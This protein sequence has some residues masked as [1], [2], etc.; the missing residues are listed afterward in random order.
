MIVFNETVNVDT[1]NASAITLQSLYEAS[2]RESYTLTNS[3][4]VS[5]SSTRLVVM[6][7][8]QDQIE[9][10][11]RT[12]LCEGQG[13]CYLTFTSA[14]VEDMSGNAVVAQEPGSY[15]GLIAVEFVRDQ[16]PPQLREFVFD[17]QNGTFLLTF[18]EPVDVSAVDPTGIHLQGDMN[19][20][21]SYTLTGGTASSDGS[22]VV[23]FTVASTDLYE[24]QSRLLYKSVNNSY[25]S[26]D[27]S[28]FRDVAYQPNQVAAI[29]QDSALQATDYI[30]DVTGPAIVSYILDLDSDSLVLSFSEVVDIT[31]LDATALYFSTLNSTSRVTLTGGI[32][33]NIPLER[34]LGSERVSIRLTNP[35]TVSLKTADEIAQIPELTCLESS[36][37]VARDTAGNL[38]TSQDPL[39]GDI[40]VSD[41]TPL[42]LVAFDLDID[43]GQ[44][45]LTFNDVALGSTFNPEAITIQDNT[46][47]MYQFSL[48]AS[49]YTN[50]NASHVI[51]VTLGAEDLF[52]LKSTFGIVGDRNTTYLTLRADAIDDIQMVDVIAITDTNA[53]QVTNFTEDTTPPTLSNFDLNMNLSTLILTFSEGVDIS[54]LQVGNIT[55]YSSANISAADAS[56]TLTG[57]SISQSADG[58]VVTIELTAADMNTIK[59]NVMLGTSQSDTFLS[60]TDAL[61]QDLGGNFINADGAD[62]TATPVTTFVADVTAPVLYLFTLDMDSGTLVL[63][64]SETMMAVSV[65]ANEF[66]IQNRPSLSAISMDVQLTDSAVSTDNS[67][68]ITIT[69]SP[70]DLNSIKLARQLAIDGHTTFLFSNATVSAIDMASNALQPFPQ[71]SAV[72]VY[73]Y[74]RDQTHP[75]LVNFT[76]DRNTGLFQL[77]FSEVIE[78]QPVFQFTEITI[79]SGPNITSALNHTLELEGLLRPAYEGE[80]YIPVYNMTPHLSDYHNIKRPIGLAFNTSSTF[81]SLTSSTTADYVGHPVVPISNEMAMQALEVFPDIDPPPYVG[82]VLNVNRQYLLIMWDDVIDASTVMVEQVQLVGGDGITSENTFNFTSRSNVTQIN[83]LTVEITIHDDD[84]N[85]IKENTLVAADNLTTFLFLAGDTVRDTSGNPN[86][87]FTAP[88]NVTRYFYDTTRPSLVEFNVSIDGGYMLMLFS[89]TV[90]YSSLVTSHLAFQN[91]EVLDSSGILTLTTASMT[92]GPHSTVLNVT[93]GLEDLNALKDRVDLATTVNDT[94]LSF[95]P[96][97]LADMAGNLINGR[98]TSNALQATSVIPDITEPTL[99]QFTLNLEDA[100]ITLYFSETVDV[101]SFNVTEISL[102]NAVGSNAISITITNTS[103]FERVDYS[104]VLVNL[105]LSDINRIKA[106]ITLGTTVNDTFLTA[107]SSAAKDRNDN[108][109]VAIPVNRALMAYNVTP[110][111][112]SPVLQNFSVNLTD[113][114]VTLSFSET[115]DITTIDVTQLTFISVADNLDSVN[116]TLTGGTD[117]TTENSDIVCFTLLVENKNAISRQPSLCTD[118]TN[119]LLAVTAELVNDTSQ[120]PVLPISVAAPLTPMPYTRDEN[121][122]SLDFFH[123]LDMNS[124]ILTILFLETINASTVNATEL[125][126]Q[127]FQDGGMSSQRVTLTGGSVLSEDSIN[128][129]IRLT[130]F[131][132]NRIKSTVGLCDNGA[133]DCF[134]RLTERFAMDTFGLFIEPVGNS[135]TANANELP[136]YF[137]PDDSPPV[138]VAF[139][140]DLTTNTITL[141]FDETIDYPTFDPRSI[142]FHSDPYNASVSFGLTNREASRSTQYDPILT[143]VVDPEDVIFLKALDSLATS[144]NDTYISFSSTLIMD[145]DGNA[146]VPRSSDNALSVR[147]YTRDSIS[148]VL[149]SFAVMDLNT[150]SFV[151]SFDEPVDIS[152]LNYTLVTLHNATSPETSLTLTPGATEYESDPVTDKRVIRVFLNR[153]DLK[154]LKLNDLLAVDEQT[155]YISFSAGTIRDQAGNNVTEVRFEPVASGGFIADTV[156]PVLLNFTLDMNTGILALL[157]DDI[158]EPST[159]NAESIRLQGDS[160]GDDTDNA[161]NLMT[162]N[163]FN[164][165]TRD[166]GLTLY[167]QRGDL[168]QLKMRAGLATSIN[169]TYISLQ[170]EAIQDVSDNFLSP[171]VRLAAQQAAAYTGDVTEPFLENFVLNLDDFM[172]VFYF[173]EAVNVTSLDITQVTLQN[174]AD[175]RNATEE[176]TLTGGTP[177][178]PDTGR[179]ITFT[180]TQ[181]DVNAL[182]LMT[183]LTTTTADTFLS[184]TDR[185]VKDMAGNYIIAINRTQGKAVQAFT[186]DTTPP[187]ILQFHLDMDGSPQLHLTFQEVVNAS[188]VIPS[189][190]AFANSPS[191]QRLQLTGGEVSL[192]DS[193]EVTITLTLNDSNRLKAATNLAVSIATTY[194]VVS[195]DAVKDLNFF[196]GIEAVAQ[197]AN[198]FTEDT[199]RPELQSFDL[200]ISYDRLTLYFSETV[201]IS[202]LTFDQISLFGTATS[203]SVSHTLMSGQLLTR[204]HSPVLE[205][206][207]LFDDANIIKN[208]STLATNSL[209][210][211]IAITNLTV[212]DT[213]ANPVLEVSPVNNLPVNFTSDTLPPEV[214]QFD[215]DLNTGELELRF[216]ETV[217]I[218]SL[219]VT[220]ITLTNGIA[221][222]S[223]HTLSGESYSNS[224]NGP[225]VVIT[226]AD[227]D[228]NRIKQITGLAVNDATTL[229]SV[230][231]FT[232]SDTSEN[233]VRAIPLAPP[234]NVTTYQRD[235]TRPELVSFRIHMDNF[236]PPLQI[237][238]TFSETVRVSTF[239]PSQLELRVSPNATD[240]S[241]TYTLTTFAT[242]VSAV[243]STEVTV[244]A[245]IFDL[246]QIRLVARQPLGLYTNTTFLAFAPALVMDMAGNRII[247]VT[248]PAVMASNN[249]ADLVPPELIAFTLDMDN[250]ELTLTFSEAVM[251]GTFNISKLTLQNDSS[252]AP[253][254]YLQLLGSNAT[255]TSNSREILL[256]LDK[257]E[258]DEIKRFLYLATNEN[259]T[260]IAVEPRVVEDEAGN[261]A[262]E[263]VV[264]VTVYRRDRT[265]PQL[266]GFDFNCRNRFLVL[267]FSETIS[268]RT[269]DPRSLTFVSNPNDPDPQTYTLT[270]G[271]VLTTDGTN[272]TLVVTN[273][274]KNVIK[275]MVRLVVSNE[276]TYLSVASTAIM[277]TS[278]NPVVPIPITS[279]IGVRQYVPDLDEPALVSWDLDMDTG[280]LIFHFNETVN[281]STLIESQFTLQDSMERLFVN[282]S[283]QYSHSQ[284]VNSPNVTIVLDQRDLNEIKRRQLCYNRTICYLIF[285]EGAVQDM[286]GLDIMGILD[287]DGQQ[288][289]RFTPDTTRP[290]LVH[291][292]MI[293]VQD[294]I[295]ILSFSETINASS[296]NFS[297]ITLQET[298][299]DPLY[300]QTL[301]GGS[302]TN[303][304]GTTIL[305]HLVPADRL[306]LAAND[307]LCTYYGDCYISFTSG[308]VRDMVRLAIVPSSNM[309]FGFRVQEFGEDTVPPALVSFI[310]DLDNDSLILTFNESVSSSSL[311]PIGISLQGEQNTTDPEFVHQLT[312]DSFT[313]SDNGHIIVVQLSLADVTALKASSFAKSINDTFL[314]LESFAVTDTAFYPPP[315]PNQVVEIP[316]DSALQASDVFAD[317]DAPMLVAFTLDLDSDV[318]IFT[319]NEPILIANVNCTEITLHNASNSSGRDIGLTDCDLNHPDSGVGA[320]EV[321][322]NLTSS[323]LIA[324]KVDT[325]F[326]TSLE[327]TFVSFSSMAFADTANLRVEPEVFTPATTYIADQT[328]PALVHFTIDLHLGKINFTFNDVVLASTF[329]ATSLTLQHSRTSEEGRTFTPSSASVTSSPDGYLIVLDL[330]HFDLLRLKENTGLAQSQNDTYLTFRASL[331]DDPARVDVVPITDTKGVRVLEFRAD[332]V[333]PMLNNFTL[334]MNSGELILSFTD[335]VNTSTLNTTAITIQ[336]SSNFSFSDSSLTL[337]GGNVTRSPDALRITISLTPTDLNELKRDLNLATSVLD[338]YLMLPAGVVLDLGRNPL[339]DVPETDAEQVSVF[340][341]DRTAPVLQNFTLDMN[342]GELSLTFDEVVNAGSLSITEI[343]LHGSSNGTGESYQL[344]LSTR[345]SSEND[346]TVTV[347]LAQEDID[348]INRLR[349]LAASI[350]TTFIAFSDLLVNDMNDNGVSTI[351]NTTTMQAGQFVPDAVRPTLVGYS[352]D[353]DAGTMTLY[354]DEVIDWASF[355]ST[356]LT[357][358]DASNVSNATTAFQLGEGTVT[359]ADDTSLNFTLS[360]VSRDGFV[361]F[362]INITV[363]RRRS[364][365]VLQFPTPP[366]PSSDIFL[367]ATELAVNDTFNNR[368]SPIFEEQALPVMS[369]INDTTPPVLERFELNLNSGTLVL[370]FDEPVYAPSFNVSKVSISNLGA[371]TVPLLNSMS[372]V[373][374]STEVEVTISEEE[375]D[376]IKLLRQLAIDANSTFIDLQND[377]VPDLSHNSLRGVTREADS[378]TADTTPP[379]LVS[380]ALDLTFDMLQLTFSE[381]VDTNSLNI[382]L[383]MLQADSNETEFAYV[384]TTASRT[385]DNNGRVFNITLG[386]ADLNAIKADTELAV[387]NATSFLY[388]DYAS[389][390]DMA[391]NPLLAMVSSIPAA[392][393]VPD[394]APPQLRAS[395]VDLNAG[396]ITLEFSET[397]DPSSF[398]IQEIT[399]Q[400]HISSATSNL[401]L[402]GGEY[403]LFN[404]T[405]VVVAMTSDDLNLLKID[406][407]L[408]AGPGTRYVS[409]SSMGATDTNGNA[410]RQPAVMLSELVPDVTPPAVEGFNL[411]MN[412]GVLTI[413]FSEA[414][415]AFSVGQFTLQSN[416]TNPDEEF[417]FT[418]SDGEIFSTTRTEV[419]ITLL[420]EDL[421]AIKLMENLAT[422]DSNAYLRWLSM[423]AMDYT[424]L[425][426]S[427]LNESIREGVQVDVFTPDITPPQLT[428]FSLDLNAAYFLNLTFDEPVRTD[429]VNYSTITLQSSSNTSILGEN[430]SYTLTS[431]LV[432]SSNGRLVVIQLDFLDVVE[433]QVRSSLATSPSSTYIALLE[434]TIL[435]MDFN[436]S[437]EVSLVYY[438]S[439]NQSINKL[440]ECSIS[441]VGGRPGYKLLTEL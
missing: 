7:S 336:S 420:E 410:L 436:P 142:T 351:R 403:I 168:D 195:S 176:L 309:M 49:S 31:S 6:L 111:T 2:P 204:D 383:I 196:N 166:Y 334:D 30:P 390:S 157:F 129:T 405:T 125:S 258:F 130:A 187:R 432:H 354:F 413:S 144:A 44:L 107:T 128:V 202:T 191:G 18:S 183:S 250:G 315:A 62:V 238:L 203:F 170:A 411:D 12:E 344:L 4:A 224:S 218:S 149:A 301:T 429:T 295:I 385:F 156:S 63:R 79:Q 219:N 298:Y 158:I 303:D 357:F 367:S 299:S 41:L 9:L 123:T 265:S 319:F 161:Y 96:Q 73:R 172:I 341:E 140:L 194:L 134:L 124:G 24:I 60:I 350:S 192:N 333:P 76:F 321:I 382:S 422:E 280:T 152:T 234:L 40:V 214:V 104:V 277:D 145:R 362:R 287:G 199:T 246:E 300:R 169:D 48:T 278:G 207:I 401:T 3:T 181:T 337:T 50:T 35:D 314:S 293:D 87:A 19:T 395:V 267:Y 116:V 220:G 273:N 115:I 434:G 227:V 261:D 84:M 146:V 86:L 360:K 74:I 441:H 306:Q 291:F 271:T 373:I 409:M 70:N 133:N 247:A 46:T 369:I 255:A 160:S 308:L 262:L 358:Q 312:E 292:S 302:T 222:S 201:D 407:T 355:D 175:Y 307:N 154:S 269:L 416:A 147:N 364:D 189:L 148:P 127:D 311:S 103:S 289:D 78:L 345:S 223:P 325:S 26:I 320:L 375:L 113:S 185:F 153:D 423:G 8:A 188:S 88:Q 404:Y 28:A 402:S 424:S 59:S 5:P 119:C 54:T 75:E 415:E 257:D 236:V 235:M 89:E 399:L 406:T 253:G 376:A 138:L 120:N 371:D 155:S 34:E 80:E 431:G 102:Q 329:D 352:L 225:T 200:D 433:L 47:A 297:T 394:T 67:D 365:P 426:L 372:T 389:I 417:P 331:V 326:A 150:G 11:S 440:S 1:F 131:D 379:E 381:A 310:L 165:A 239:D 180:M 117:I 244:T 122:T 164:N 36:G 69:L 177:S 259:N 106:V 43:V 286:V 210:T 81:L 229:L 243:D 71:S 198:N 414:I 408:F 368:L 328:R 397:I 14:L 32:A 126:L 428:T 366:Y 233:A 421:D 136:Q 112:T 179:I 151:L 114:K 282:Y 38:A 56:Y 99:D 327:N 342:R 174:T 93:F 249:T 330:D 268:A 332:N 101:A 339:V 143:F 216:S 72:P 83:D 91:A 16:I 294:G 193:L 374:F 398:R 186:N 317:Q 171:I 209:N 256:T 215:L 343:I 353:F 61:V 240:P 25:L 275:Q 97:A 230:E 105:S 281:V 430:D 65:Q 85:A 66:G 213:N 45:L 52:Q 132:L 335:T 162:M 82:F 296:L 205:I 137:I 109:L 21:D 135:L 212:N 252:S 228:L 348:G 10:Q 178:P 100:T 387:D 412:V 211:V 392:I 264:A 313:E 384:L 284:T 418:A 108:Q 380:F 121:P 400:D 263:D 118:A 439:I 167:L 378:F 304:D 340:L 242:N 173:S 37:G 437:E 272:L 95:A 51:E 77:T 254:Q 347:Y 346:T 349:S 288:V 98:P 251:L 53:I 42:E 92:V 435:D 64:F 438:Y 39:C 419:N 391:G 305:F 29:P 94:Y 359:P 266:I 159:L 208:I 33:S 27:M 356:Q 270:R 90:N 20:T 22:E 322:L 221:S 290:Q 316:P 361:L 274:D 55:L 23:T 393:F 386:S 68:V 285:D 231:T 241:E 396:M 276:T 279:A 237:I 425:E 190:F 283:I 206:Q 388:L 217:N 13:S 15:P 197:R 139:D 260:F 17:A 427:A 363:E 370:V 245:S 58:R 163:V 184:H 141:E 323:D 248:F 57:G 318:L 226:L 232:I 338:T 324:I 377:T 182:K 110:D